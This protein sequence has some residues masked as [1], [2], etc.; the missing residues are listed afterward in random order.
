V[1][2]VRN[3]AKLPE[4]AVLSDNHVDWLATYLADKKNKT[5]KYRYRHDDI[6]STLKDETHEKCAYCESKIGHNSPG[7]VEHKIP[8]S[9]VENL[10]FTW[11]NLTIACTE[12][13]RRK[14][15]FYQAHDGFLD[16]YLED[17][18]SMLHHDGPVVTAVVGHPRAEVVVGILKLCSEERIELVKGKIRSIQALQNILERFNS[19]PAG[20]LREVIRLQIV[21]MASTSFEYSAMIRDA[22]R[23]KG[24]G[25]LLV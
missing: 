12:C 22:L 15:A 3:L 16:P 19:T 8:S 14:N 13:N 9:K 25:D 18:E 2:E 1:I 21:D 5:N 4:P 23:A 11:A 6:K 7:D 20:A 10:H 17:V 24:F